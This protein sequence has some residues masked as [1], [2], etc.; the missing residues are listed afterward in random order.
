MVDVQLLTL[1]LGPIHGQYS[2]YKNNTIC[3]ENQPL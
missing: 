3:Q 2:D 1:K